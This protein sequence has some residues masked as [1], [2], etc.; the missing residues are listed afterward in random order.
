VN[1]DFSTNR[2][3]SKTDLYFVTIRIDGC[4]Y[5]YY[6]FCFDHWHA[7]QLAV[8]DHQKAGHPLPLGT[9][10][11][12]DGPCHDHACGCGGQKRIKEYFVFPQTKSQ[13]LTN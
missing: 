5:T 1:L 7:L 3:A 4:W 6:Y 9:S 2:D 13:D 8:A 10:C 11:I 12:V